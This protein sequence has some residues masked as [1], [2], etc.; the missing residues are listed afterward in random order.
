LFE[1]RIGRSDQH[2]ANDASVTVDLVPDH[3]DVLAN[4]EIGQAALCDL[5]AR[6]A[7]LGRVNPIEPDFVLLEVRIQQRD[8]IAVRDANDPAA[9]FFRTQSDSRGGKPASDEAESETL[10]HV[11]VA[12]H[13]AHVRARFGA[14]ATLTVHCRGRWTS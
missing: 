5:A 3:H 10:H 13:V 4:D 11:G 6:L 12:L 14:T 7:R 9:E 8:R 1:V 2:G